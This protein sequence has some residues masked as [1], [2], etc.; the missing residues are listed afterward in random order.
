MLRSDDDGAS[1]DEVLAYRGGGTPGFAPPGEDPKAPNVQLGGLA[2]DPAQPDQVYVGRQVFHGYFEPPA[3]GAVAASRD[4]GQTWFDLGRQDIGAVR[5]LAL[6][7]EGG[8][9]FAATDQGL[10]RLHLA[11]GGK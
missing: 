3:G 10:W 4:G 8:L 9:L 2:Y 1:W 11:A 7:V 6:S 5:D